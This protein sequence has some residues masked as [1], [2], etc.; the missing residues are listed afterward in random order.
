MPRRW[1]RAR[2]WRENWRE[3]VAPV[4]CAALASSVAP[5]CFSASAKDRSGAEGAPC[6]AGPRLRWA[7]L[8]PLGWAGAVG[9]APE[10]ALDGLVARDQGGVGDLAQLTSVTE[11][12]LMPG[13]PST[14][15]VGPEVADWTLSTT[16][17]AAAPVVGS[18]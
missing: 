10:P 3:A 18:L 7:G 1:M 8:G 17:V 16:P 6:R 2:A 4:V 14:V 9:P 11:E 13:T 15:T 5:A 12:S